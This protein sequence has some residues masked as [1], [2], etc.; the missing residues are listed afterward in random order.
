MID[1][2]AQDLPDHFPSD[3]ELRLQ[4]RSTFNRLHELGEA[5]HY[6]F[7]LDHKTI[8]IVAEPSLDSEHLTHAL[9]TGVAAYEV[10]AYMADG[11]K[12]YDSPKEKA[13]VLRGAKTFV[14]Q[15]KKPADFMFR[16]EY[17][18]T[19]LVED[20]PRLTEILEAVTAKHLSHDKVATR[21]ALRGAAMLRGMQIHVD[22]QLDS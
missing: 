1:R 9:L 11:S 22:R 4:N 15:I 7:A 3:L 5:A 13:A 20:A 14:D 6:L 17:A 21:F 10:I 16:A 2:S 8:E 19:R 18:H 12:R